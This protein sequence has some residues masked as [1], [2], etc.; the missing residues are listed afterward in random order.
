M[1]FH[2]DIF[3]ISNS[4]NNLKQ[5]GDFHLAFSGIIKRNFCF[6]AIA[7]AIGAGA[8]TVTGTTAAYSDNYS[9]S[10]SDYDDSDNG[11][12]EQFDRSFAKQWETNPPRGYPTLSQKNL[13]PMKVAVKRYA[14]IVAAGGWRKVPEVEMKV[15]V[16]NPA[17]KL[18]RERLTLTGDL[19][20]QSTG[21]LSTFDYYVEQ[22]VKKFQTRH[23]L[24]PTGVVG[25]ETLVALNIPASA[26]LRQLRLNL[27]RM[28]YFSKSTTDKYVMAN[29]AAA[30]VE[31]VEDGKVVSR[32][33]AIVGKFDR[34]T[35]VLQSKIHEINFNPFWTLPR[36]IIRK[37]LVPQAQ[38]YAKRGKDLLEVVK[39]NVFT[40][41][42]EPVDSRTLD[43]NEDVARKY[44]FKQDPWKE[45]ALGFVKINFHNTHAVF[46]HDTPSKTLFSQNFR[47]QSSG[48]IRVQNIQQLIAWILKDNEDWNISRIA[49]VKRT[50]SRED[51][52]VKK[53]IP[54]F[55]IYLTAWATED[56]AVHFRPDIYRRD[57]EGTKTAAAY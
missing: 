25:D 22:A 16:N 7:L 47:A 3:V 2:A 36:S 23:G 56:S 49:D 57:A 52:K 35:P 40:H 6:A 32:H 30:Q 38:E 43:W 51:I 9:E 53:R 50:V 46:L 31:A 8:W 45:N 13:E 24:A 15:G 5:M 10:G 41:K 11:W 4:L 1:F 17:V 34:R 54:I 39:I 21:Y 14:Q 18:L 42:G 20:H 12:G 29:I 37:D 28:S 33:S 19:A 27:V 44:I 48:C 26:R 55:L